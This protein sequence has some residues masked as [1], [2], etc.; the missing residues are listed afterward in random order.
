MEPELIR[1]EK[2]VRQSE[3][4]YRELLASVTDYIYSVR[5]QDG[6]LAAT[7]HGPGCLTVTKTII[8]LH[9]GRINV[10]NRSEGGV[11]PP[12]PGQVTQTDT[13]AHPLL[14]GYPFSFKPVTPDG[15]CKTSRN[16]SPTKCSVRCPSS[17]PG[18][19]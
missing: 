11:T 8:D 12:L 2:A 4:R 6:K 17:S 9:G 18:F 5:L 1:A 10:I 13:N 14:G 15:S 7:S 16:T 19:R 3:Q